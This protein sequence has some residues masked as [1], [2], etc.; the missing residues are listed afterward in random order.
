MLIIFNYNVS[1]LCINIK[2]GFIL[3]VNSACFFELFFLRYALVVAI[4]L[5]HITV[6]IF[7][8][9]A[10]MSFTIYNNTINN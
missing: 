5:F 3:A 10:I 8:C 4:V 9:C 7:F 6:H 2:L 1:R